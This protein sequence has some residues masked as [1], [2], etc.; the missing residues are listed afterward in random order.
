MQRK[1]VP[2]LMPQAPRHRAAARPWPSAKPP[3]AMKG[4]LRVWR[5]RERRMKFVMS[6][7]PTWLVG[8]D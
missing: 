5:A 1:R 7:S 2:M 6:D 3:E 8:L 4:T